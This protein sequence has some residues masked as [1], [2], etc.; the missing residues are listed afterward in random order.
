[1]RSFILL[2]I[3][4]LLSLAAGLLMLFFGYRAPAQQRRTKL[5]R[6]CGAILVVCSAVFFCMERPP[7]PDWRRYPTSDGVASAEFPAPPEAEQK[8]DKS[9]GISVERSSLVCNLPYADVA[10]HLSFS[11]IPS[12]MPDLSDDDVLAACRTQFVQQGSAVVREWR[13]HFGTASGF[14][15]DLERDGGKVRVWVRVAY[16]RGKLYRVVAS[17]AGPHDED[18]IINR[19]LESFRVERIQP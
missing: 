9:D 16:V 19:F 6:A 17:S 11:P 12:G 13:A 5:L 7:A 2:H 4:S 8:M 15:L 14:A 18:A 10:L 1:M 3:D